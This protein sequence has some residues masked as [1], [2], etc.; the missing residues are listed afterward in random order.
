M[1]VPGANRTDAANAEGVNRC[2]LPRIEN[3]T[4]FPYTPWLLFLNAFAITLIAR[5]QRGTQFLQGMRARWRMALAGAA[6]SM[7][8][9][10]IVLWA[11]SVA[12]IPA[13]AALRESSVVFAAILGAWLLKERMGRWRI[14]G[15]ALVML[16]AMTIRWS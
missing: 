1:D 8:S 12:P 11:M 15:A 10:G 14:A 6:M 4:Q 3:E 16:G 9:Y 7:C 2:Q 5:W 13:V